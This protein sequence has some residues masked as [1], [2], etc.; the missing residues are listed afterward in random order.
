MKKNIIEVLVGI[1]VVI[2][3]AS[4]AYLAIALGDVE[5][6]TS[7][8]YTIYA[9]FDNSSGLKKGANVEIAGVPIG[10]VTDIS[11][12]DYASLVALKIDPG[13]KIPDDSIFAIRT[14]GLIG[15]KFVKVIPGGSDKWLKNGDRVNDTESSVSIEELISKYIFSLQ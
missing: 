5:V 12:Q 8:G 13:V 14:N 3:L 1:F 2:G 11:L 7:R 6:F 4:M 15:D 9:I 10:R